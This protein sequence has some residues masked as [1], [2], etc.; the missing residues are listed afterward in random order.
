[1]FNFEI[2]FLVCNL[3]TRMTVQALFFLENSSYNVVNGIKS[4]WTALHQVSYRAPYLVPCCI[5]CT[6]M[7]SC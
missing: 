5:L 6:S 2:N 3:D 1:M 7:T 4:H